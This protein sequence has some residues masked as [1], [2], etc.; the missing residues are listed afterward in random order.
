VD[1]DGIAFGCIRFMHETLYSLFRDA[2]QMLH[3]AG[4]KPGLAVL[5]VG[6]GPGF[7]TLPAARIVGDSGSVYAIDLNRHAVEHVRRKITR[8]GA[9]NVEVKQL[10]ATDT[11]FPPSQ[12]DLAF[13]F[14]FRRAVGGVDA[15]LREMHRVLRGGG[16][17][18]TEGPLSNEADP[19]F[20]LQTRKG[21]IFLYERSPGASD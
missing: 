19:A 4:L 18:S 10:D 7:F 9:T 12:F 17:L 3:A 2:D 13:L 15:V 20:R 21:R 1:V 6:C 5:E 14:G 8:A 11:G 16:L